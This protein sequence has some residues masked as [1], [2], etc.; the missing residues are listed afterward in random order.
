MF[1]NFDQKASQLFTILSTV[2]KNQK[3]MQMG[4]TRNIN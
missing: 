4:I 2:V 3:E 1:E